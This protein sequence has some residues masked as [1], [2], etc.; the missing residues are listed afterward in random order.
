MLALPM[1]MAPADL[2]RATTSASRVGTRSAHWRLAA[3]VRMPA[4][5]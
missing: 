1:R 5:S 2:R 3:V 4:V